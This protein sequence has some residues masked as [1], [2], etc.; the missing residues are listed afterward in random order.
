MAAGDVATVFLEM[1]LGTR[2]AVSFPAASTPADLKRT[3][4]YQHPSSLACLST[5]FYLELFL[6]VYDL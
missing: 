6:P 2:L 5:F 4:H 3:Y 1:S